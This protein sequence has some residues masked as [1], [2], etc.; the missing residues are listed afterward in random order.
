[1]LLFL[2]G[3]RMLHPYAFYAAAVLV[4]WACIALR[5]L[6]SH[7]ERIAEALSREDLPAARKG[8]SMLVGRDTDRMDLAACG[9]GAIESMSENLVDGVLSPLLFILL[10]GPLGGV[11][12]KI[13]STMDSMVGYK[14]ERYLRFG[15]CGARTDDVLNYPVA[16]YTF[17][18]ICGLS[19]M[20]SGYNCRKAW[21]S[22]L[23]FHALVPGPN[24]GWP[25]A[26]MAGALG[27]RLIGPIYKNG[28]QVADVWLGDPADPAGA[29]QWHIRYCYVLLI[30]ATLLTLIVGVVASLLIHF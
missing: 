6:I 17:L 3:A 13:V 20:L 19:A 8:I 10:F 14:I 27:I 18:L 26:S 5:D 21:R 1:V 15:W 11:F 24:S 4:V 28:I 16:R 9:R 29:N 25:E 2:T 22:G 12:F 7:A 30:M 23:K